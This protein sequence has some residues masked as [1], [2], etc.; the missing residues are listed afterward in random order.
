MLTLSSQIKTMLMLEFSCDMPNEA[1][2]LESFGDSLERMQFYLELEKTYM[3]VIPDE[4]LS[5]LKTVEDLI[6]VVAK[7]VSYS[8]TRNETK[9]I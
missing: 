2:L 5:Q 4:D 9:D 7:Y 3:V 6:G 1:T 8:V